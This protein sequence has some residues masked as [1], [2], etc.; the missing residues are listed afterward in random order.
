MITPVRIA[1]I[2]A[3]VVLFQLPRAG[4]QSAPVNIANSLIEFLSFTDSTSADELVL[5]RADGTYQDI[6]FNS[7]AFG[8]AGPNVPANGLYTYAVSSADPAVGVIAITSG[9]A[10]LAGCQLNFASSTYGYTSNSGGTFTFSAAVP[11]AGA[12]N[13]STRSYISTAH[14]VEA[15]FVIEGT[16]RRWVLVRG[17]GPS[18]AQFGVLDGLAKP[19]VTV[20]SNG[21]PVI[22]LL[23]WS[24]D[25]SLVPGYNAI[26]D[27]AGAF[28]YTSGSADSASIFML[29]PGA[30]VAQASTTGPDGEILA[31]VYILPFGS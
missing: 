26:F 25:P 23:P 19:Q 13:V 15:G 4:A 5:F 28:R 11:Q 12:G 3:A 24:G 29:Q 8:K 9:G 6:R 2:A 22:T 14:P 30:Y 1:A 21:T 18:L 17:V 7:M 31:E 16:Q 20:F 10:A 27:V